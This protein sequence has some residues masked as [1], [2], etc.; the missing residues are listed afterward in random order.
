MELNFLFLT[1]VGAL[2]LFVEIEIKELTWKRHELTPTSEAWRCTVDPTCFFHFPLSFW[3]KWKALDLHFFLYLPCPRLFTHQI[4]S[5]KCCRGTHPSVPAISSHFS[6]L[7][8][9]NLFTF[10]LVTCYLLIAN[11]KEPTIWGSTLWIL[12]KNYK[13]NG[14]L[15]LAA[16]RPLQVYFSSKL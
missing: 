1:Q 8:P 14:P 13:T 2:L 10:L 4:D 11:C 12:C 6:V 3:D 15:S 5:A 7:Q 9:S 16:D